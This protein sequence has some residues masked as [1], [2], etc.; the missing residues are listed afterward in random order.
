LVICGREDRIIESHVV[1]EAVKDIP[2]Y[3]F[4]MVANCGHAP[5][6]ECPQLINRMVLEF[7]GSPESAA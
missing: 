2:N 5:Q 6:L 7:L 3:R 1:Q 4:V